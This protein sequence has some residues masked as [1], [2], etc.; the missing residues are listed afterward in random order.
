[1]AVIVTEKVPDAV[2][3][4]LMTPVAE[5]IVSPGGRPVAA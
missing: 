4:P 2:G 5:L 3:V 1:V